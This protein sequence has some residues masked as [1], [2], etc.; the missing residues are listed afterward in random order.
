MSKA[1]VFES[2]RRC[3]NTGG[4]LFGT[5]ILN[6]GVPQGRRAQRFTQTYNAKGI[7]GNAD[8]SLSDVEDVLK[9]QFRSYT[10][11]IKE[12]VAFFRGRV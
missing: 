4:V 1:V 10:L 7:F 11:H 2:L 6:Q 9:E 8:D 3:V 12:C 5:T